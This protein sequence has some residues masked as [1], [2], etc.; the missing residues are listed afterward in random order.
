MTACGLWEWSVSKVLNI[1]KHHPGLYEY[2]AEHLKKEL[3]DRMQREPESWPQAVYDLL[4][5]CRC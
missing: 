1:C 5:V 3:L 4:Q 2:L